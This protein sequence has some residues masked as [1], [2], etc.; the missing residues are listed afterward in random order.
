[1]NKNNEI[2]SWLKK[3]RDRN[4]SRT[5]RAVH[6][7]LKKRTKDSLRAKIKQLKDKSLNFD[8]SSETLEASQEDLNLQKGQVYYL[9]SFFVMKPL[10]HTLIF[11]VKAKRVNQLL[12]C[13]T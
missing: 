2:E 9:E 4:H 10:K 3:S 1:M 5:M 6:K 7:R 8:F 13:I 11:K 12:K